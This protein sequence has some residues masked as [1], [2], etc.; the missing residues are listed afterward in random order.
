MMIQHATQQAAV[1]VAKCEAADASNGPQHVLLANGNTLTFL[2]D[3]SG[4]V[5]KRMVSGWIVS[6]DRHCGPKAYAIAVQ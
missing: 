3:E 5:K 2:C 1:K 4:T 6:G